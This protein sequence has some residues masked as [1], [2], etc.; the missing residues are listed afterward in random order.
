[1]NYLKKKKENTLKISSLHSIMHPRSKC[2]TNLNMSRSGKIKWSAQ[3][4]YMSNTI[5]YKQLKKYQIILYFKKQFFQFH[6][7]FYINLI[8]LLSRTIF[9]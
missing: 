1:M 3:D 6:S 9:E 7:S 2:S 8:L 4:Q 5:T